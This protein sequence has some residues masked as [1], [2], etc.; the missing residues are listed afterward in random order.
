MRFWDDLLTVELDRGERQCVSGGRGG[1]RCWVLLSGGGGGGGG[2]T[3]L[4]STESTRLGSGFRI[5]SFWFP[6]R[7]QDLEWS[8]DRET[9]FPLSRVDV[10]WTESERCEVVQDCHPSIVLRGQES[11]TH[12]PGMILEELEQTHCPLDRGVTVLTLDVQ[13]LQMFRVCCRSSTQCPRRTVRRW[14]RKSIDKQKEED[15]DDDEM[16]LNDSFLQEPWKGGT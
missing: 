8:Q 13:D 15:D 6:D 5:E 3:S 2:V 1:G 10:F 4:A 7:A 14:L 12:R 11:E 16:H 9:D